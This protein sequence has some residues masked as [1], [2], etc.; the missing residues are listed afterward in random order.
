MAVIGAGGSSP[1]T[2][3][4]LLGQS[5]GARHDGLIPAH[6]GKTPR[7]RRGSPSLGAHPRSRGENLTCAPSNEGTAGSSPL[8]RGKLAGPKLVERIRRLIPAHA[9]KTVSGSSRREKV[10][11]HPRSR[12]ENLN[13]KDTAGRPLGSSPLTRGKLHVLGGLAEDERLIPAHA[14]KTRASQSRA[15]FGWA[16]PRSRGENGSCFFPALMRA[17]SSPLTRGKLNKPF[18]FGKIVGLIPAHAGK[19]P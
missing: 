19:T 18:K 8:T 3:G 16:H 15:S 14:G 13:A 12:G 6:A 17:G 4:K 2:R 10:G 1:L 11:A 5:A 7:P 9:G